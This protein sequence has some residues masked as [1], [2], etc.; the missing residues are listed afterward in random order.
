MKKIWGGWVKKDDNEKK[1]KKKRKKKENSKKKKVRALLLNIPET[2]S[3]G[4]HLILYSR[5]VI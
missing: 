1:K 5:Y 3:Y 2:K 4:I